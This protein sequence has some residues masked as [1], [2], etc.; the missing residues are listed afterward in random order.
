METEWESDARCDSSD[1]LDI[2]YTRLKYTRDSKT[3]LIQSNTSNNNVF[4]G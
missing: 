4:A 1:F 3:T 2:I